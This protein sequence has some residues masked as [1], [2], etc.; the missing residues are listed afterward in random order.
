[1]ATLA[2]LPPA[3]TE[4]LSTS[5]IHDG[6]GH[7]VM[8]RCSP[9][10]R[11]LPAMQPTAAHPPP[12]LAH[13]RTFIHYTR[14]KRKDDGKARDI[15]A[16]AIEIVQ[17]QGIAGLSMEAVARHAGVATSTL[18]VY[19]AS[20]E[21]LIDAAYLA[22]KTA[23]AEEVFRET[24]LPV[25]PAL[26]QLTGAYLDYLVEHPA[27]IAFLEQAK[28]STFISAETRAAAEQ[29]FHVLIELIERGKREQLIKELELPFLLAFLHGALRDLAQALS[30]LPA[31]K[32]RAQRDQMAVLCWDAIKR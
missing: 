30:R 8:E 31:S 24:G 1:M 14:V 19:H 16:A 5:A 4:K 15:L 3:E 22:T 32:R 26:L 20:K 9:H 2:F 11:K 27:E 28:L 10:Q 12:A 18:Y 21:A 7:R 13:Y 6:F 23:L 17:R 29:G 25:R